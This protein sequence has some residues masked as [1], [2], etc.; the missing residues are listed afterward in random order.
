MSI[1]RCKHGRLLLSGCFECNPRRAGDKK[2]R[3]EA[4][5]QYLYTATLPAP[6]RQDWPTLPTAA[7]R[8]WLEIARGGLEAIA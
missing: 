5:A 3:V 6:G 4:L 8:Q 7:K 1:L 2:D